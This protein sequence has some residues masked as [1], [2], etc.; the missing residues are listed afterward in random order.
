MNDLPF[1]FSSSDDR[2]KDDRNSGKDNGPGNGGPD[3]ANPFGFAF[4]DGGAVDPS[5]LG[6][7][8][9]QLG[10]MFSG[11]GS[12]MAGGGSGP[13]NYD[14]ATNLARQQIGSFTPMLDKEH[15][16]VADAVRLA[17]VWLDE[18]TTLPAGI[19]TT[20]AWTPVDW[21]E[22]TLPTWKTLCDPIAEQMSKTMDTGLP[23]EAQAFAGPMM[24]MIGQLSG[25]M[26]GTQLG[27]GLGQLAGGVLT[28]TDIGLPLA[29]DRVGVLL[30]EAIAKFAEGL[31]L[32]AQ[33]IV[34]FLAAREAA[35]VRLFSHVPWL[36]QRL[37][38]TV[39]EYARGIRI[40]LGG[41]QNLA[42]EIDPQEL[43]TNPGK[44]EELMGSAASFEPQTTPEQQAAL[45]RLETLLALVE[46]WVEQ[47]VSSALGD[48]IPSTAA[49]TET[50][51]RRRASGGPAEQTFATLIGMDLR[52]RKLREAATLWRSLAEASDIT[53]RDNVWGHPDLLPDADDLDNPAGFIDRV[54]GGDTSGIDD[55]IAELERQ[56]AENDAKD[57]DSDS[58][59]DGSPTD[60][61]KP[62]QD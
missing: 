34:V 4:G 33:E 11:M 31:D 9:S 43:F 8:F 28:S 17:E 44:L 53:A 39:E 38:A 13:V 47:V 27:Q 20:A 40:D 6:Q 61:K 55:A 36:K 29:P 46:G 3:P 37:L 50:M 56:F 24:A 59:G 57:D 21:L 45:T 54:I 42:T 16:A 25:T 26:Y 19:T 49:L 51:R 22:N 10:N 58:D 41:L 1:G 35:H 48:R 14:V 18:Q 30:P 15:Q 60:G 62:D 32:P 7:L 5:Q 12:G 23:E 2:D 52:P